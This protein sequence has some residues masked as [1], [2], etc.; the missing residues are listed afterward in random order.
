MFLRGS[1]G[2]EKRVV[3]GT[4]LLAITKS[5]AEKLGPLQP[6]PSPALDEYGHEC[7]N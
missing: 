2:I 1:K 5:R 3:V 4:G 6:R 7:R